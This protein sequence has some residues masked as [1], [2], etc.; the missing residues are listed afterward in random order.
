MNDFSFRIAQINLA[1]V[2]AVGGRIR[3][4]AI[5]DGYHR[6]RGA[7]LIETFEISLPFFLFWL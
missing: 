4:S 7:R 1:A 5:G 2:G 6:S 3:Q